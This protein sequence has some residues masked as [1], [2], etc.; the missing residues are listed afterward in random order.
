MLTN[1]SS[2]D[3]D[4]ESELLD[5][6]PGD[7]SGGGGNSRNGF[8]DNGLVGG[9]SKGE[10]GEAARLRNGLFDERFKLSPTG[11]FESTNGQYQQFGRVR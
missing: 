3:R 1:I 11:S 4:L 6:A 7:L 10:A 8:R 9:S 2:A 5:I